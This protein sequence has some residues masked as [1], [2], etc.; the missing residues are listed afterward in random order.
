MGMPTTCTLDA[1]SSDPVDDILA[2]VTAML[3]GECQFRL[4]LIDFSAGQH[5]VLPRH[6]TM[7]EAVHRSGNTTFLVD[8]D[9]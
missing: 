4:V 1:S 9:C 2:R 6:I 7:G 8:F 5:C 3:L